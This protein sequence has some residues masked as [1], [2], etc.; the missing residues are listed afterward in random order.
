MS[1]TSPSADAA[2]LL[3]F[4]HSLADAAAVE[5]LAY[6]KCGAAVID[7]GEPGAFDP[8]TAADR[9]AERVMREMIAARY[10]DHGIHGEEFGHLGSNSALGWVLDPIDGTRAY[11]MGWP[12]W[13]TLIA[14]SRDGRPAIGLM[15]QPYTGERFWGDGHSAFWRQ[16]DRAATPLRTRICSDLGQ[17]LLATT[18]PRLF[19]PG[20]EL[21]AFARLEA[22][23]RMSRYGGDCY[24]YVML[25]AG[26]TDLVVEAG[27]KPHDI[28]A[29]IP[30]I[31]GAGGVITTW[32]GGPA[33]DG[34]RIIAAGDA[35]LHAAASAVL[36]AP[37]TP[38]R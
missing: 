30:I 20:H 22:Q 2:E 33:S 1:R 37:S 13:G 11:I 3:G 38:A 16:K 26:L 12:L 14:A 5:T 7:K 36:N 17:A 6:F 25:A 21:A 4:A 15:D 29:L 28:A 8:V 32:D 18:D 19:A 34:G 24:A 31:E 27:L 23:V 10:P 9:N 35:R